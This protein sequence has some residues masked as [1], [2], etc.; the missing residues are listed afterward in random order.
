MSC[1]DSRDVY[2]PYVYLLID[3]RFDDYE[4]MIMRR[5]E[6]KIDD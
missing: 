2:F 3:L 6:H 1:D 5:W 4:K